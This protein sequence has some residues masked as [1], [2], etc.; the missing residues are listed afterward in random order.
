LGLEGVIAFPMH[1][2][3]TLVRRRRSWRGQVNGT[4]HPSSLLMTQYL[5]FHLFQTP[6]LPVP[7]TLALSKLDVCVPLEHLRITHGSEGGRLYVHST[8]MECISWTPTVHDKPYLHTSCGTRR[9]WHCTQATSLLIT[10][11]LF[12]SADM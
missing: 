10:C 8:S 7:T 5:L 12:T 2:R 6:S 1:Q 3:W 9:I 11:V 4:P